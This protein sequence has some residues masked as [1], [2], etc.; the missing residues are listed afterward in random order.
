MPQ[1][2]QRSAD[3]SHLPIGTTD[4]NELQHALGMPKSL[5]RRLK[6][7]SLVLTRLA[8]ARNARYQCWASYA[9]QAFI[10]KVKGQAT[11][12]PITQQ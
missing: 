5:G 11:E 12:S 8:Q 6:G 4:I 9:N 3:A 7:L 10:V 2:A 1:A